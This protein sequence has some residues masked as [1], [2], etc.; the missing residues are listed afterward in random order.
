MFCMLTIIMT[1]CFCRSKFSQPVWL[2]NMNSYLSDQCVTYNNI[3]PSTAVSNC[4]YSEKVIV[5]CSKSIIFYCQNFFLLAYITSYSKPLNT[6]STCGKRIRGEKHLLAC[7][8]CY[9]FFT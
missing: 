8:V 7:I 1:I 5:E 9:Y 4:A 6:E 3:C 2:N